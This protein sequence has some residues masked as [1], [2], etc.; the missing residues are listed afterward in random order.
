MAIS[1]FEEGI[2]FKLPQKRSTSSWIQSA[3][4]AEKRKLQSLTFVFCSDVYLL[5]LNKQYLRHNTLTDIL[6]FSLS[7][8]E[9]VIEG[10]IYISIDRVKE[11]A[12]KFNTTLDEELHRVMI[13]GVL[14]LIGYKDKGPADRALMREKE[15]AYLS[16]R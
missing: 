11:N 9:G 4:E 6:T 7:E 5:G 13:H 2:Y 10:E 16:L 12:V 8:K 1:F 14:H 15:E 3:I